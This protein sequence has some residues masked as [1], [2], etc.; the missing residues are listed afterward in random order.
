MPRC[1]RAG[2]QGDGWMSYVVQAERYA[3][4]LDKIRAAAAAAGRSLDGF[5]SAHLAFITLG[6]DCESA[7]RGVGE[8]R[9]A[10]VRAGLRAA[11]RKVRDHRYARA[12]RRAARRV[13][14]RRL[15]LLHHERDRRPGDE[16]EQLERIA[17]DILPRFRER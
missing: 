3:Q 14:G 17:A 10:A 16:R 12:V 13:R 2:R 8:R 9:S 11:R 5:A 15:Q 7:K 6:R 1:T 4:S